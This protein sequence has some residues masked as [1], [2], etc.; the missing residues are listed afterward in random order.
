MAKGTT[1]LTKATRTTVG[2]CHVD[3]APRMSRRVDEPQRSSTTDPGLFRRCLACASGM[4]CPAHSDTSGA[5]QG[6]IVE[7]DVSPAPW[8]MRESEFLGEAR[9]RL[10]YAGQAL[11]A[12]ELSKELLTDTDPGLGDLYVEGILTRRER[13]GR[14]LEDLV[15]DT[16]KM[17]CASA[18]GCLAG[19]DAAVL[20]AQE[21]ERATLAQM[22]ASA[23]VEWGRV[24]QQLE[25][26]RDDDLDWRVD[27]GYAG[28][29]P[30]GAPAS[31][32]E[33]ELRNE[34]P[35]MQS[36]VVA[37]LTGI[38]GSIWGFLKPMLQG[39]IFHAIISA[40]YVAGSPPPSHLVAEVNR[41]GSGLGRRRTDLRDPDTGA[42]IEIK[43][44]GDVGGQAQ[45]A[46]YVAGLQPAG[47]WHAERDVPSEA[48]PPTGGTAR[49]TLNPF[50]IN[51]TL[52]AC[53]GPVRPPHRGPGCA[54]SLREP[55]DR[56]PAP[57]P[58]AAP[59]ARHEP[60]AQP[61]LRVPAPVA[62]RDRL[63]DATP[64]HRHRARATQGRPARAAARFRR[65]GRRGRRAPRQ[66]R[67]A[68]V[69][70]R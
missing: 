50:G 60:E 55:R 70:T 6:W 9:A 66:R 20:A 23:Q 65:V 2:D 5:T 26:L 53:R 21:R 54:R 34:F 67:A 69:T 52:E 68:I 35:E 58:R 24:Q 48:W 31:P 28:E 12:R 43:P 49:Y 16:V 37:G 13:T 29:Q 38:P 8:Q 27:E 57:A 19:L 32:S 14:S 17:S 59:R 46:A 63:R 45:L 56:V 15:S 41:G 10:N 51:F 18:E 39:T 40:G 1:R 64:R 11:L 33:G 47:F 62:L 22:F 4:A 61:R 3:D 44:E 7:D 42:V 36:P 25:E 30:S